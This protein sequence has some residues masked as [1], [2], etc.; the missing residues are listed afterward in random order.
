MIEFNTPSVRQRITSK[1]KKKEKAKKKQAEIHYKRLLTLNMAQAR[2]DHL[3]SDTDR[4]PVTEAATE[5]ELLA[6]FEAEKKHL[7]AVEDGEEK[8]ALAGLHYLIESAKKLID[9]KESFFYVKRISRHK[10]I[11]KGAPTG[12]VFLRRMKMAHSI[13]GHFFLQRLTPYFDLLWQCA[14][15][16]HVELNSDLM[17]ATEEEAL[18]RASSL[19]SLV[20]M[21]RQAGRSRKFANDCKNFH[22]SSDKNYKELLKYV[23]R[24]S[25]KNLLICRCDVGV[26]KM[27]HAFHKANSTEQAQIVHDAREQLFEFIGKTF[28]D[29][30]IGFAWKLEFG[31]RRGFHYHLMFLFNGRNLKSDIPIVRIIGEH[32]KH[33]VMGGEGTY[34]NCNAYKESYKSCGI[35]RYSRKANPEMWEGIELMC[36][37]LTKPDDLVR[38]QIAGMRVFGKG[39]MP[40]E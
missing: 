32:W 22:R 29:N 34:Y 31:M 16:Y 38:L 4:L 15:K 20:E 17:F 10:F 24:H 2:A 18:E 39:N 1:E 33:E 21:I 28:G 8:E 35:G 9:S 14:E 25:K 13:K 26:Q 3:E 40:E 27:A 7:T 11:V 30:F 12:K 19:N 6:Q 37:Y 23:R 5:E 36:A